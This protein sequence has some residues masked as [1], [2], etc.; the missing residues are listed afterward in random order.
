MTLGWHK[1]RRAWN[2]AWPQRPTKRPVREVAQRLLAADPPSL[3]CFV[4][5]DCPFCGN[6]CDLKP[7]DHWWCLHCG[8]LYEGT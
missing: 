7:G 8:T 4:P 2:R 1:K 6:E 5:G 3:R